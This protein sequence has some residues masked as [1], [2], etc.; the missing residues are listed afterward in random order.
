MLIKKGVYHF[1]ETWLSGLLVNG[2]LNKGKSAILPIFNS[3]EVLYSASDKAIF[4]PEN[5]FRS[6]Q[7]TFDKKQQ[8]K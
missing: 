1:P 8:D 6:V 4:L 3:L 7:S 2:V 5:Y